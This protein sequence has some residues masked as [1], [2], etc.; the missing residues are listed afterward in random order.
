MSVQ[1]TDWEAEFVMKAPHFG[2]LP[3]QDREDACEWRPP[4]G[5]RE[6]R[7]VR[8]RRVIL[9][10]TQEASLEAFIYEQLCSLTHVSLH[11]SDSYVF[12][13]CNVANMVL[14]LFKVLPRVEVDDRDTAGCE[15]LQEVENNGAVFAS[16]EGKEDLVISVAGQGFLHYAQRRDHEGSEVLGHSCHIHCKKCISRESNPGHIDGNDVFYH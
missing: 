4:R 6:E 16:V 3:V 1:V 2:N 15:V 12:H 14:H 11:I 9:A 13:L 5:G 10:L 8:S 7:G